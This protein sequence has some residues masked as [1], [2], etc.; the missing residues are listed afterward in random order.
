M[1]WVEEKSF[2]KWLQDSE[3]GDLRSSLKALELMGVV[4]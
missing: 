4:K 2:L 3:D 1:S